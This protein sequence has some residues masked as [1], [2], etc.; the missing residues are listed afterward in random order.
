[1]SPQRFFIMVV[2]VITAIAVW[3]LFLQDAVKKILPS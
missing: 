2:V 1:M 3:E